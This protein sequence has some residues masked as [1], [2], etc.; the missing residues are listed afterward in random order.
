[1]VDVLS[2]RGSNGSL[3]GDRRV[4]N[5]LGRRVLGG[6]AV[7]AQIGHRRTV[8]TGS[9]SSLSETPQNNQL[10]EVMDVHQKR[11]DCGLVLVLAG[12]RGV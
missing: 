6:Y 9:A 5:T 1:M 3:Q 11:L 12:G 7:G 2:G 4:A 10:S 8:S